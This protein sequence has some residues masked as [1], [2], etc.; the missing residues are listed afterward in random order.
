MEFSVTR[1]FLANRPWHFW[2][3]PNLP[4]TQTPKMAT[5]GYT[6][7]IWI[8]IFVL[9][10]RKRKQK[11]IH[12]TKSFNKLP[13]IPTLYFHFKR[14]WVFMSI[15]IFL[16][17]LKKVTYLHTFEEFLPLFRYLK[18]RVRAFE[19]SRYK[20]FPVFFFRKVPKLY[21]LQS[22]LFRSIVPYYMI[23]RKQ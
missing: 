6:V 3:R 21:F 7:R 23:L 18:L 15:Q 5:S 19:F 9:E 14:R 12:T 17:H 4:A 20:V 8:L 22:Y 1:E 11:Q 13:W 10:I 16:V 2:K